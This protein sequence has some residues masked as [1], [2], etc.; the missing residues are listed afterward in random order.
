MVLA[1]RDFTTVLVYIYMFTHI[2]QAIA[3]ALEQR[4][5]SYATFIMQFLTVFVL[6]IVIMADDWCHFFLYRAFT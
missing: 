5:L 4:L 3:Y 1:P 2:L 6:F